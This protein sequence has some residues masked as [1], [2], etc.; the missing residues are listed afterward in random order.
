MDEYLAAQ[1]R[2]SVES[3]RDAYLTH[4]Y[5]QWVTVMDPSTPDKCTQLF[6]LVFE[7]TNPHVSRLVDLHLGLMLPGCRCRVRPL[8]K[9]ALDEE[10]LNVVAL[11]DLLDICNK[12]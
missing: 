1:M 6:R 2:T 12:A 11:S 4:P 5:I 7:V 10:R 8:S 9:R 3:C